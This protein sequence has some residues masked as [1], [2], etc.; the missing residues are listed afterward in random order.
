MA[1]FTV[2]SFWTEVKS[3]RI[4]AYAK[5]ELDKGKGHIGT[6]T[7]VALPYILH[8]IYIHI[9]SLV[10]AHLYVHMINEVDKHPTKVNPA[11]VESGETQMKQP[12]QRFSE[13]F[14]RIEVQFRGQRG[15]GRRVQ[16]QAG[17]L[18][19]EAGWLGGLGERSL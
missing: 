6:C 17:L 18:R 16:Q 19:R 3:R 5:Q 11:G 12:N 7:P 1:R 14:S 2:I 13:G 15:R 4:V 8:G 9:L 10:H